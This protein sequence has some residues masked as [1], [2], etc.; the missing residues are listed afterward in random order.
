MRKHL[1]LILIALLCLTVGTAVF[2]EDD[3]PLSADREQTVASIRK[4]SDY[5]DGYDLYSMEVFYAYDL[6][7]LIPTGAFEEDS[8]FEV[9]FDEAVPGIPMTIKSPKFGCTAF[10][11]TAADGSVYMGRNYDW[12]EKTSVMMCY[13]H[14]ENGYASVCFSALSH[15]GFTDPFASRENM[16]ACLAAPL[17]PLDGMNEKGVSIAVL[18]LTS[19]PTK[20]NT[21]KPVLTPTVL[22]RLVL[23]R[24]AS[25]EEAIELISRYDFYATAGIDYHFYITDASGNGVVVEWDCDDP[26]R[27]MVVTPVRTVTNYYAM[28]EDKF[29]PGQEVGRYGVGKTRRDKAEAVFE[30]A[31]G[32]TDKQTAW[33]G[34]IAAASIPRSDYPGSYTE[35][36]VV[37]DLTGCSCEITLRHRWGEIF[38]FK[39][40]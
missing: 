28:Y 15:F 7:A 3:A 30:A 22:I 8:L 18:T 33:D 31:G 37:Y 9:L 14:P 29:F 35:W 25:T 5:A 23:D 10:T 1:I 36:T 27:S 2:A 16:L 13:C 34:C 11:L 17:L 24:A 39:L 26:D 19:K 38:S 6:D 21:G 12:I 40:P 20:Q 4:L 32:S